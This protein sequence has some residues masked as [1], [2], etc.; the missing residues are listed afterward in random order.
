MSNNDL[1]LNRC[2]I[3]VKCACSS[4]EMVSIPLRVEAN[5]SGVG[6]DVCEC[7]AS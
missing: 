4:G 5:C 6:G 7:K 1:H 3:S 2:H